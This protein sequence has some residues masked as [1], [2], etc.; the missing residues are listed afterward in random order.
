M[1]TLKV[2]TVCSESTDIYAIYDYY[3]WLLW[4]AHTKNT[5]LENKILLLLW[6]IRIKSQEILVMTFLS[7][8]GPQPSCVFLFKDTY[9]NKVFN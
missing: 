9:V 4:S 6:N 2:L 5:K 7:L 1:S 8:I 3:S